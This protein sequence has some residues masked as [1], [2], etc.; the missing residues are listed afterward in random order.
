MFPP[1]GGRGYLTMNDLTKE[2][3][4][5]FSGLASYRHRVW[6]VLSGKFFQRWIPADAAV[7]DLGCGW[8]EFINQIG[9]AKKYGMDLNEGASAKLSPEVTFICQDCSRPWPLPENSLDV[10]F[11]SNF[12]EHLPGKQE[13]HD[14]LA[15]IH[16][17]LKSGRAGSGRLVCM[18]PNIKYLPGR[19]WDFWDHYLPLTELSLKEGLE[20]AG[21]TIEHIS[22]KFLP[23][24]MSQGRT[25]PL[26]MLRVYLKFPLLWKFFGRQFLIIARKAA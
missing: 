16:R 4:L 7:L 22:G 6:R 1:P 3:D 5:R 17:C 19:Y 2:Y 24:S 13:L 25:P 14:T 15:Q 11:T 21:F 8:G 20:L 12:F 23:Y 9:A 10:V 26:W 18:G